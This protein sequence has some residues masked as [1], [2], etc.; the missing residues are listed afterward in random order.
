MSVDDGDASAK[1]KD[2]SAMVKLAHEALDKRR[3]ERMKAGLLIKYRVVGPTEEA[4]LVKQG[5]Y[6]APEAFKA[7]TQEMKDF[8]K[9]AC[10]DISLGGLKINTPFPLPEGS[11]LWLQVSVPGVPMAVN[12][13]AEVRW[14]RHSGSLCSSGVKFTGISNVDL[15]KVER[16]LALQKSTEVPKKP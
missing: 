6:A 1:G 11:R 4:T 5:D 16:Y 9:V 3:Y 15:A 14:S 12:A 7:S 8:N 10:E 2:V 13:I